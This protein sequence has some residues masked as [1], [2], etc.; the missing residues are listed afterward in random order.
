MSTLSPKAEQGRQLLTEGRLHEARTLLQRAVQAAPKD[1]AA[2]AL[3]ALTL[4]RVGEHAQALYY[5]ETVV[6]LAPRDAELLAV[7]AHVA[8]QASKPELAA[9]WLRRAHEAAPLDVPLS[10]MLAHALIDARRL[11]EAVAFCRAQVERGVRHPHLLGAYTAALFD[12]GYVEEAAREM[13]RASRENPDDLVIAESLASAQVYNPDADAATLLDAHRRCAALRVR[14]LG[15]PAAPAPLQNADPERTLRI[16]FLGAEFHH[17]S[18]AFFLEPVLAGLDRARFEVFC[19]SVGATDDDVT[20]QLRAYPLT[21]RREP[22]LDPRALAARIRA[23]RIDI[24]IELTGLNEGHRL[25]AAALRPAPV[26]A[27]YLSHLATLGMDEIAFRIVDSLTDPPGSEAFH[28]E[29]LA[30]LDPCH[31]CYQPPAFAAPVAPTPARA[32]GHIAFGSFNLMSKLNGRVLAL[33]A[34]VMHAVPNSTLVL[35]NAVVA[36]APGRADVAARFARLGI[37]ESRLVMLGR[38]ATL[39]EHLALYDRVDVCLDCFPF[40]GVTT[41]FEALS[42]GVPVLALAGP[43]GRH[44]ARACVS[45]LTNAGLGH[46]LA[47]D[48]DAFVARAVELTRD[49]EALDRLRATIRPTLLASPVCDAA[50]FP[51][52]FE[53]VLRAMWREACAGSAP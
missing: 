36:S 15:G 21:W 25:E 12:L 22:Q 47:H 33:W 44:S 53:A 30:R 23:D 39:E 40:T 8:G 38:T 43:V 17:H 6:T 3:L 35:K 49:V 10:A 16:G 46:L 52:R 29:R 34:R 5:A 14:Q 27:H 37:D 42:R 11:P 18:V 48:E 20:A 45:I 41:T 13:D 51:R 19:Y 50:S 9:D 31:L 2:H 26:Q 28:A 4:G 24:L 32:T 7:A 1:S